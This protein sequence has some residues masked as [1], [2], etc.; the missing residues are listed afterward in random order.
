MS[1]LKDSCQYETLGGYCNCNQTRAPVAAMV[2][3]MSTVVV[4]VFGAISY[5]SL[6]NGAGCGNCGGYTSISDAYST[7]GCG[8]YTTRGCGC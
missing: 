7:E 1:Y 5:D 4:P 2:P 8:L 3:S 6:S